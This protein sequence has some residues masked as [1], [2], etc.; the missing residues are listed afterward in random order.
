MRN[1]RTSENSGHWIF[2]RSVAQ[3]TRGRAIKGHFRLPLICNSSCRHVR[4]PCLLRLLSKADVNVWERKF[5]WL[6]QWINVWAQ[7]EKTQHCSRERSHLSD[8]MA[9][10]SSEC[11]PTASQGRQSVRAAHF[12]PGAL[13]NRWKFRLISL[14]HQESCETGPRK[15]NLLPKIVR[16]YRR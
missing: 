5:S 7:H 1:H 16:G 15:R 14:A 4:R 2:Q 10:L 9:V 3:R 8:I 6:T 12:L 13:V 11:K